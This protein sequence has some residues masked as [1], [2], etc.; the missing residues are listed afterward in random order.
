M[1]R[2]TPL[3]RPLGLALPAMLLSTTAWADLTPAQVWGDWKQYMQGMGYT[4]T[5]TEAESGGNLEVSDMVLVL[6][7]DDADDAMTMNI[8]TVNFNQNADGS[9]SIIVPDTLP[10]TMNIESTGAD[11]EMTMQMTYSQADHSMTVSGEPNAMT[12]TYEAGSGSFGVDEMIIDGES[13]G[14]DAMKIDVSM[15]GI[16]SVSTMNVSD[17]RAYKQDGTIEAVAYDIFVKNPEQTGQVALSGG[18][19][20][21]V[22]DAGGM[23]PLATTDATDM[24]AMIKAGFDISGNFT[25]DEGNT[26][27]DFQDEIEGNFAGTTSSQGGTL[28]VEM[29][30]DGLVYSGAQTDMKMNL[31]VADL[32]FPIDLSMAKGAFNLAMPVLKSD[33]EQDFAFGITLGDFVMSDLI[34]GIFDPAAQLPRDPATIDLDLTGKAKLLIDYLDPNA[35]E[36]MTGAPG[37]IN[38]LTMNRLT[39]DAA[40][41]KLEGTGDVTFDNSDMTTIPGMPKP[42]GAVNLSLAGGNTLLDKLV[43]M[44]LLPEDQAMGARMMMGLFAVPGTEPDT[45][46]SK[47]EFTEDG[48]ILANGQRIR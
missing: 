27:V 48:Q 8:G 10:I 14:P 22:M 4:V 39:V 28:G 45:L 21:V 25:Y 2:F 40:G 23:I 43:G 32:P 34:W 20:N 29:G 3:S 19:A 41:A 18:V 16:S 47:I 15:T 12:Y 24:S 36:Q 17:M 33:E 38:A 11:P 9:V 42:E 26:A 44:G 13:F 7:I 6:A 46:S 30:P 31:T 1:P 37:E 35:A 5:A